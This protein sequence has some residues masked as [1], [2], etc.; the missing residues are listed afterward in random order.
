MPLELNYIIIAHT[1]LLHYTLRERGDEIKNSLDIIICLRLINSCYYLLLLVSIKCD[2]NGYNFKPTPIRV[3]ILKSET[4]T[5]SPMSLTCVGR[6]K[7]NKL[8]EI[9]I[10]L[11]MHILVYNWL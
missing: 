9:N 3:F 7:L 5:I 4:S 10:S 6:K 2:M 1:M 11:K 8:I